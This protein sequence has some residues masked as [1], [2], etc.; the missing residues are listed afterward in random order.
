M[1]VTFISAGH[2]GQI[3]TKPNQTS[4]YPRTKEFEVTCLPLYSILLAL[5][6]PTVDYFSLDVEGAEFGVLKTI[7]FLEVN[8][9]VKINEFIKENILFHKKFSFQTL[10]VEFAHDKDKEGMKQ[11]MLNQDY[12]LYQEFH[13]PV[14]LDYI[15]VK[16]SLE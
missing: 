11:F 15:F 8:I 1:H 13:H 5:S 3:K 6:N 9:K 10:S 14:A 12:I 2:V 4:K 7:P 16:K